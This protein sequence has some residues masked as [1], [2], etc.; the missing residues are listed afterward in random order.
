MKK[1][2]AVLLSA[3]LAFGAAGCKKNTD[4]TP[5]E[6]GSIV[7]LEDTTEI[8][9][10]IANLTTLNPLETTSKGVQNIMNIVYEPLF[11]VDE[12]INIVPVLAEAIHCPR[13][14]GG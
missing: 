6:S 3:V 7:V 5:E 10:A 11:T 2:I 12:K 4:D 14:A 9:L 1:I 8:K 13:M